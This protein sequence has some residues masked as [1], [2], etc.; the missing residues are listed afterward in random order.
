MRFTSVLMFMESVLQSNLE[1]LRV[2]V[3]ERP[4]VEEGGGGEEGSSGEGRGVK[5]REK[6]GRERRY[7]HKP[8]SFS[9]LQRFEPWMWLQIVAYF[10]IW[11][12]TALSVNEKEHHRILKT[13]IS[14]GF[15]NLLIYRLF[16]LSKI[17]WEFIIF[18]NEKRELI[19]RNIYMKKSISLL[20]KERGCV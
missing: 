20:M 8:Q 15:L 13:V 12:R 10:L 16:L 1:L 3:V 5:R 7:Y 18:Y 17:L 6:R 19:Y 11:E 4:C 9:K 14:S 2:M